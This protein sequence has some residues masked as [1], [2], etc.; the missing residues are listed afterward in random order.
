MNIPDKTTTE[1]DKE[2]KTMVNLPSLLIEKKGSITT[3][4]TKLRPYDFFRAYA[5]KVARIAQQSGDK[6]QKGWV[7]ILY[8]FFEQSHVIEIDDRLIYLIEGT[9]NKIDFYRP[10][11]FSSIFINA[12]FHIGSDWVIKGIGMLERGSDWLIYGMLHHKPTDNGTLLTN[13]LLE[14]KKIDYGNSDINKIVDRTMMHLRTMCCNIVDLV[15]NTDEDIEVTKIVPTREQQEKRR[16]RKKSQLPTKIFIRPKKHFVEYLTHLS[17][18]HSP[19][20]EF[21]VMGHW[22][23][24]RSERYSSSLREKPQWIKAHWRGEGIRIPKR[25]YKIVP[26]NKLI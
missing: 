23:H 2:F 15:E 22:R 11:F 19:S 12:E 13:M 25:T 18:H 14:N 24:Y 8:E 4:N 26:G 7:K 20:H 10:L 16:K 9:V 3:L 6:E 1:K 21:E 5:E 17:T